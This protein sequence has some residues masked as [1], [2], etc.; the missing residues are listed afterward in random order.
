MADFDPMRS[1]WL[2]EVRLAGYRSFGP[3]PQTLRLW[4]EE[5]KPSQW[6]LILGAAGPA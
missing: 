4:R 6:T 3:E 2:K 5:D 1:R